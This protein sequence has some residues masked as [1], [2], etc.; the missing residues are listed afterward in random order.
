MESIMLILMRRAGQAFRINDDIIVTIV[1]IS[2]QQARIGIKA[3][4]QLAVHREEVYRRIAKQSTDNSV[5]DT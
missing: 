4:K 3:P 5:S 1:E 2:G